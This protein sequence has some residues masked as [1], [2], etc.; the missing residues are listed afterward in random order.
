MNLPESVHPLAS[1]VH[2]KIE[3]AAPGVSYA[4]NGAVFTWGA[5]SFN[6]IMMLIG[7]IFAVAT[8]FTSLYFQK[9]RE[10]RELDFKKRRDDREQELH[11]HLL[12]IDRNEQ[13]ADSLDKKRAE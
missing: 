11:E 6:Q 3:S 9:R 2:T 10:T 5:I 12:L 13:L 7:T 1:V 4:A 8:Y